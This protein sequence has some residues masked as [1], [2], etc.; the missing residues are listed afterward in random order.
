[1]SE[2]RFSVPNCVSADA[3]TR[4]RERQKDRFAVVFGD[5]VAL[6]AEPLDG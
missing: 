5:A 2:T 6:R 3:V 1:M 4:R